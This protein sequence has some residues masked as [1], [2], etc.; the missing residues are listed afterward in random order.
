MHKK[1][2]LEIYFIIKVMR[3]INSFMLSYKVIME[4]K[5]LQAEYMRKTE[6]EKILKQYHERLLRLEKKLKK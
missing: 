6:I 3:Y 2:Y 1:D 5:A 4:E